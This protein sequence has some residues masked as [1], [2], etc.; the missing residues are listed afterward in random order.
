M[1]KSVFRFWII[2]PVGLAMFLSIFF[3][4]IISD[5]LKEQSLL[6]LIIYTIL[7]SMSFIVWLWIVLGELRTKAVMVVLWDDTIIKKNFLGLGG[8]T[9]FMMQEFDGYST[10]VLFSKYDSY[11]Y[12]YL[13][14][15]HKKMIKL[16]SLYHDN[17]DE[18]K[19]YLSL[20]VH[21]LGEQPFSLGDELKE[22]FE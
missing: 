9:P 3:F 5:V 4:F 1:I 13:M 20:N 21:F 17:Y 19:Q 10:S 8:S 12:L 22:I 6:V 18:M 7:L 14:K 15:D 2:L 11:E 16:S